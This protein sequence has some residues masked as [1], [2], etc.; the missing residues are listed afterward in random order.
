MKN[1]FSHNFDLIGQDNKRRGDE[2][3]RIVTKAKKQPNEVFIAGYFRFNSVPSVH[4][5]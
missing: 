3:K 4:H 1:S 5:F 2:E